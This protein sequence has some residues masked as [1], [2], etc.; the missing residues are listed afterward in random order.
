MVPWRYWRPAALGLV[1]PKLARSG[2]ARS[3]AA[4]GV[5]L[6]HGEDEV[7][8][9]EAVA[10]DVRAEFAGQLHA[11]LETAVFLVFGIFL[12]EEPAAG[13]VEFRIHLHHRPAD[14]Q[15]PR[16]GIKVLCT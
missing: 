16:G 9:A 3:R 5:L 14:R 2:T 8:G 4:G 11:E 7:A 13:G 1:K 12:D 15:D 10:L 6:R